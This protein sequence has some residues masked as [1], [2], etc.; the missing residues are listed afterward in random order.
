[1]AESKCKN[2]SNGATWQL[3]PEDLLKKYDKNG[4][5]GLNLEA[6]KEL[7]IDL[8]GVEEV[9]QQENKILE[10]FKIFDIDSDEIIRGNEWK[11]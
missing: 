8:F 5:F 6:F 10:I 2:L 9:Q 7:C 4:D 1:M 3:P 11:T